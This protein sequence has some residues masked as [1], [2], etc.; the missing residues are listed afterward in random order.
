M[1][2]LI[3]LL[4]ASIAAFATAYLLPGVHIDHF[5]TAIWLALVL[6]LLNGILR[7]VLI[8]LTLPI[9]VFTLGLFLLVINAFIILLAEHVI[10]GFRVDGFWWALLFSIVMSLV[11]SFMERLGRRTQAEN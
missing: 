10:R 9:T 4:I 1:N 6:A 2:F 11:S 5:T 3:R 8:L 7:P